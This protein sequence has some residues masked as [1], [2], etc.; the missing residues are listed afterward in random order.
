ML[1]SDLDFSSEKHIIFASDFNL[2][3]DHFLDAKGGSTGLKKHSSRKLLNKVG[4]WTKQTE[5]F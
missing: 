3:L 5:K 4:F 1:L 2:F